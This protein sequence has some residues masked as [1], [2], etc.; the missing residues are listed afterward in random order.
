MSA[1]PAPPVFLVTIKFKRRVIMPQEFKKATTN[2]II[3]HRLHSATSRT[4]H[5]ACSRMANTLDT[6][7]QM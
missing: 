6:R 7:V 3:R 4:Y 5:V 2:G 1:T